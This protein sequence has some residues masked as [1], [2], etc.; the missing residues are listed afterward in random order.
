MMVLEPAKAAELTGPPAIDG[1]GPTGAMDEYW[2]SA[3][4]KRRQ[5]AK[6]WPQKAA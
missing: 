6:W 3:D 4:E 5:Q 2:K 1:I